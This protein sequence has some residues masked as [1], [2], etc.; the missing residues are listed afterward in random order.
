MTKAQQ[1][2]K[3]WGERIADY[4][5]SGQS[6]SVWCERHEVTQHQLKYWLRKI[7]P[8]TPRTSAPVFIPV[9]MSSKSSSAPLNLRIGPTSIDVQEGFSPELLRQ[10]VRALEMPC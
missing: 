5:A 7:D 4:R 1:R 10:I 8:I 6:M 3:E 9:T 2:R